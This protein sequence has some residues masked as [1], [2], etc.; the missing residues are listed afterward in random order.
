LYLT[1]QFVV[2][3][4]GRPQCSWCLGARGEVVNFVAAMCQIT[5][6]CLYLDQVMTLSDELCLKLWVNTLLHS[7]A[8]VQYLVHDTDSV[9]QPEHAAS[10]DG[11]SF[12]N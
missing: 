3:A 5:C 6:C 12:S 2:D 9:F 10:A 7:N 4:Q 11:I 8:L 1:V